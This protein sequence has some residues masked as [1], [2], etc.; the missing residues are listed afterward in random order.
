MGCVREHIDDAGRFEPVALLV[1]QRAGIARERT[2]MAGH[3]DNALRG[4]QVHT[5]HD[6]I[7]TAARRIQQQSIPA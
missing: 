7:R 1:H 3:V 5:R 4:E 2:R 6:F